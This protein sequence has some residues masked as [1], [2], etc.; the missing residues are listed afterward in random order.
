M[1]IKSEGGGSTLNH[2]KSKRSPRIL[3]CW[4]VGRFFKF[5]YRFKPMLVMV[6]IHRRPARVSTSVLK[7]ILNLAGSRG[8]ET[9]LKMNFKHARVHGAIRDHR[10]LI[11]RTNESNTS[12]ARCLRGGIHEWFK[13]YQVYAWRITGLHSLLSMFQNPLEPI[14]PRLK[15]TVLRKIFEIA[16]CWVGEMSTKVNVLKYH[17][18]MWAALKWSERVSLQFS[19]TSVLFCECDD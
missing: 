4:K 5:W 8:V 7:K 19:F 18:R 3:S 17:G 10:R 11:N 13:A 15:N 9:E 12:G 6:Y 1:Y 14:V 16:W 2:M